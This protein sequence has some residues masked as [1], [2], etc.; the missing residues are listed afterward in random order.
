MKEIKETKRMSGYVGT[1]STRN[2]VVFYYSI[3]PLSF[4]TTPMEI[5][6]AWFSTLEVIP[7]LIRV[8]ANTK[9]SKLI[10]RDSSPRTVSTYIRANPSIFR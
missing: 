6:I 7:E 3:P 8:I 2:I 1:R 10:H 4:N 5:D 9:Y